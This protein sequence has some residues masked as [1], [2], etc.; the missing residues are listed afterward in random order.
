MLLS[1]AFVG[2]LSAAVAMPPRLSDERV[3]FQTEYGDIEWAF[4]PEVK[5]QGHPD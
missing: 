1:L 4:L 3:V 5:L 2:V